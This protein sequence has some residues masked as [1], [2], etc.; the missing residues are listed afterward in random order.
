MKTIL[1]LFLCIP[2]FAQNSGV[3]IAGS[4]SFQTT[5]K[6]ESA[7]QKAWTTSN[8]VCIYNAKTKRGDWLKTPYIGYPPMRAG[9]LSMQTESGPLSISEKE[10]TIPAGVTDREAILLM[11]RAWLQNNELSYKISQKERKRLMDGL[12]Q[13]YNG[14]RTCRDALADVNKQF[15]IPNDSFSKRDKDLL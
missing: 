13:A 15:R 10:I 4:I 11:A 8:Q 14:L 6:C 1:L 5:D 7:G 2:C 9:V 12:D 3:V